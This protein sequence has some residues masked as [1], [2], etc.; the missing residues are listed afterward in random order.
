MVE[1][2]GNVSAHPA[3]ERAAYE[4]PLNERMRTFMRL[5]FL[6]QQLLHNSDDT[7]LWGSRAT[8][9]T[10]LDMLAI[11][12]R[13]DIRSEIQK[14]ID[15]H[16][17]RLQRFSKQPGVDSS[18]LDSVLHNLVDSRAAIAAVGTQFLSELKES[19]F[20]NAIKHRSTIPGGTC[21]FDLPEYSHWLRQPFERRD[22]DLQR[23]IGSVRPV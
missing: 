5:D 15:S 22:K 20:L 10:L 18:R 23:W 16:I 9:T 6:Y 7:A 2:A 11:L 8:I 12:S 21:E 3:T 1:P 19:D 13:G 17:T 14:E 4:L